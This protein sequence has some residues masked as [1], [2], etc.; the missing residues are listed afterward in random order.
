MRDWTGSRAREDALV[1]GCR[2]CLADIGYPC[3]GLDG[4]P[5]QA[6][7]AHTKRITDAQKAAAK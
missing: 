4:K 5:L 7:P 3:T 1:V 6:F 2:D